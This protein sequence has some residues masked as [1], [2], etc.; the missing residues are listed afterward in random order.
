MILTECPR[1]AMQGRQAFIPTSLKIEYL[2]TLLKVG[3]DVLD[4]GSFVSPGAV[5]QMSDTAKV[6]KGLE[7]YNVNTKLLAIIANMRGAKEAV[8]YEEITFLGFPFSVSE[9]FQQRNTNSSV[10]QSLETVRE[11]HELCVK[12]N[13]KLL[14]YLSMAFGNPY[15]DEWSPQIVAEWSDK[16]SEMGVSYIALADTVGVST[17]ENIKHL[18]KELTMSSPHVEFGVHL[19]SH[20]AHWEE[21]IEAAWQSGCRKFDTALR[22]FGGC[23]MAKDELVGNIATENLLNFIKKKDME[24]PVDS[25][26]YKKALELSDKVFYNNFEPNKFEEAS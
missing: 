10:Q 21:K 26:Y 19:H 3:F 16:I 9:T 2:N 17:P 22:G 5:P 4:F 8:T 12:K 15:Q 1:D 18:F 11:I 25:I 6:I 24:Y 13:K 7:L 23:P 20:P 14:V